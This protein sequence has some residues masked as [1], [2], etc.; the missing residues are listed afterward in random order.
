V[1][2]VSK[3]RDAGDHKI[4]TA[5]KERELNFFVLFFFFLRFFSF[6]SWVKTP[7]NLWKKVFKNLWI[8]D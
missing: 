1:L 4:S 5:G 2:E 7:G 3:K 8:L 6:L